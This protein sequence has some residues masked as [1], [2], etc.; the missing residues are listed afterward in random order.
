ME[1]QN[2]VYYLDSLGHL[3][4]ETGANPKIDNNNRYHPLSTYPD[5]LGDAGA[6]SK[7]S[8]DLTPIPTASKFTG[9][10][11][12]INRPKID[13][14]FSHITHTNTDN[15]RSYRHYVKLIYS[16]EEDW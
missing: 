11:A 4:T 13:F 6:L 12:F 8:V 2:K 3:L 14:L 1:F 10:W 5:Y 9:L 16:N 15:L 7:I